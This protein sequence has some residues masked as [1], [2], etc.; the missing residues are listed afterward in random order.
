MLFLLVVYCHLMSLIY[1]FLLPL[2]VF[3]HV[4]IL[5]QAHIVGEDFGVVIVELEDSWQSLMCLHHRIK[6]FQ[7]LREVVINEVF[8]EDC[9]Q[10]PLFIVH[11]ISCNFRVIVLL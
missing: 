8:F 9:D 6:S 3:K 1:Q 10:V 4:L 11:D 7:V 2:N 5:G